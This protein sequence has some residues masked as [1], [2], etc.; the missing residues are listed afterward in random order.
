MTNVPTDVRATVKVLLRGEG[1]RAGVRAVA[2]YSVLVMGEANPAAW[3]HGVVVPGDLEGIVWTTPRQVHT[4]VNNL[5]AA[6]G[7]AD[8]RGESSDRGPT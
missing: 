3:P 6:P 7:V 8:A 2:G 5:R 1:P 4:V